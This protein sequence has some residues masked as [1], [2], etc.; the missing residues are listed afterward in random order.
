M[1]RQLAPTPSGRSLRKRARALHDRLRLV[2]G[3]L[4]VDR[5]SIRSGFVGFVSCCLF[6]RPLHGD[7]HGV[8]RAGVSIDAGSTKRDECVPRRRFVACRIFFENSW[9]TH[10]AMPFIFCSFP[11]ARKPCRIVVVRTTASCFLL[12]SRSPT[13]RRAFPV[14]RPYVRP[15]FEH[16]AS[17]VADGCL[18]L[19]GR[20]RGCRRAETL[21]L[22]PMLEF[23]GI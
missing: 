21:T 11:S 9:R 23:A 1:P 4:C 12:A 13:A 10:H 19:G 15:S 17:L 22:P 6:P 5:V 14:G 3:S 16:V 8:R 20:R 18:P 2:H 7:A